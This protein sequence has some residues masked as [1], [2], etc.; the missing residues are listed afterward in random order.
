MIDRVG[1]RACGAPRDALVA[2]GLVEI[3]GAAHGSQASWIPSAFLAGPLLAVLLMFI[4][5]NDFHA[6]FWWRSFC[7]L[8]F[9]CSDS[10]WFQIRRHRAQ[11]QQLV[12]ARKP[13]KSFRRLPVGV[14]IGVI[15]TLARRRSSSGA[16]RPADGRS[17]S[18]YHPAGD[19]GD[20]PGSQLTAYPFGKL[21]QHEPQQTAAVGLLVLILADIVLALSGHR[22]AA[23]SVALWGFIWE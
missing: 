5:A 7:V 15:A 22:Y 21:R 9:S 6:I 8:P 18:L 3:R 17:R 19:G 14:A 11:T 20:E 12:E 4:W 10:A 2:D 1:S 13:G 23:G 16:V